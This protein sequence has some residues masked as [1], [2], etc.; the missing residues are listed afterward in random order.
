MRIQRIVAL[1]LL[2][3][4]VAGYVFAPLV[5]FGKPAEPTLEAF[6][7]YN[8]WDQCDKLRSNLETD[9]GLEVMSLIG[10]PTVLRD[11]KD[12][13]K[14]LYIA[15]G[16][17]R[18][19]RTA[20]KDIIRNF[21]KSGGKAIIADDYGFAD[22]F[23]NSYGVTY[24]GQQMWDEKYLVNASFPCVPANISLKPYLLVL[25][26]PTGLA[27]QSYEDP[28]KGEYVYTIIAHG[29]E[30][31]FVD[32]N[33]NGIIDPADAHDNIPVVMMVNYN[34]KVVKDATPGGKIVFISDT[35]PFSDDLN[36]DKKQL[37]N[38]AKGDPYFSGWFCLTKFEGTNQQFVRDLISYMLPSGGKV[39]FDESR[40]PQS[41]YKA[42]VYNS[43]TSITIV[44]S[45]PLEAGMLSVGL[46]LVL[47]VVVVRARDKES[48]IHR[49][50]ISSIHR[51]AMLPDTRAVQIDHLRK[52]LL[53]K[54]RMLNSL[55]QDEMRALT[56][57]QIMQMVKDAQLN[58]LLNEGKVYTM[59]EIRSVT[60][61]LRAWGKG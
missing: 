58:E 37:D 56:P 24:Y 1:V 17:N 27:N 11:V 45:N 9:K 49:F 2:I 7:D 14:T 54:V 55:T 38:M 16:I 60:A 23:S 43:I 8:S 31:S 53:A 29:S 39:I 44:T 48:W 21:V 41:G 40:H 15:V 61:K 22:D 47:L 19:Y 36:I 26:K 57:L 3:G 30:R 51:R 20:E 50:D 12:P 13:S 32:R 18:E 59:D 42:A 25:S 46:L 10:S 6:P 35:A 34:T 33:S 28:A 5:Q 52:A 4:I